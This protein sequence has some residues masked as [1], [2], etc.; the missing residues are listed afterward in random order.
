MKVGILVF[1]IACCDY[2]LIFAYQDCTV[3]HHISLP[4]SLKYFFYQ[5]LQTPRHKSQLKSLWKMQ[6]TCKKNAH[7]LIRTKTEVACSIIHKDRSLPAFICLPPSIPSLD[8]S[9]H[10]YLKGTLDHPPSL[11]SGPFPLGVPVQGSTQ[12]VDKTTF[13]SLSLLLHIPT[14]GVPSL[15]LF[16]WYWVR[17]SAIWVNITPIPC[18]HLGD[19]LCGKLSTGS[20]LTNVHIISLNSTRCVKF[21]FPFHQPCWFCFIYLPS[22]RSGITS[23]MDSSFF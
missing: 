11:Y 10:P 6:Q 16:Q 1:I 4:S 7:G 9:V 18:Y 23:I 8:P 14:S 20:A 15:H 5:L 21:Y 22:N 13:N 19:L 12:N 17:K 2:R 3:H